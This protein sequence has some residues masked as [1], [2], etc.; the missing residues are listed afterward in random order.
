[1]H[2][3]DLVQN[4]IRAGASLITIKITEDQVKDVLV[5][6]VDDNGRGIDAKALNNI[7]DPF[8]TT[9]TTRKVGLGLS[10]FREA[11]RRCDG[12]VEINSQVGKGT[13]VKGVFKW[14][15]IDRAPLGDMAGSIATLIAANPSIDF[16]YV[17]TYND[18]VFEFDTRVLREKLGEVP[19]NDIGVIRW[20]REYLSEGISNL[21]G[22]VKNENYG[23]T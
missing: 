2:V 10:L 19:L 18:N 15:H 9:R 23:G 8:Y 16:F 11:A 1:M 14:S 3:I 20:I 6:Q 4:S 13:S 17:H 7:F 21:Y 12:D 22:G 5:I